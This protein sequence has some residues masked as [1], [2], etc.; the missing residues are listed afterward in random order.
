MITRVFTR[1]PENKRKE[2]AKHLSRAGLRVGTCF[3]RQPPTT[4]S[5]SESLLPTRCLHHY[6][7][8]ST[9]F[10]TP[11]L[12]LLHVRSAMIQ[13]GNLDGKWKWD[14]VSVHEVDNQSL[15]EMMH[16]DRGQGC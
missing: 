4:I 16:H 11:Q 1:L 12:R 8:I 7:D 10:S 13:W 3:L 2:S 15:R 5:I 9:T 14:A 6:L